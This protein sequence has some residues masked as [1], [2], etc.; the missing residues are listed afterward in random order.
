MKIDFL[1]QIYIDLTGS[2]KREVAIKK[3]KKDEYPRSSPYKKF[4]KKN[5]LSKK[6]AP[7]VVIF[8]FLKEAMK[9]G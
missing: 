4:Y 2:N 9:K 5:V 6:A 1:K 7:K 8:K 3:E